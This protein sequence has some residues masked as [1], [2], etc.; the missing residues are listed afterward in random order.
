MKDMQ[1]SS[2]ARDMSEILDLMQDYMHLVVLVFQVG[3][4]L[5]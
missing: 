4:L 2:F 3:R 1:L 5:G